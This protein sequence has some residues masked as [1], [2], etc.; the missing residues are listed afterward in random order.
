MERYQ[1]PKVQ[2]LVEDRKN[3]REKWQL[4]SIN[5]LIVRFLN[6]SCA[7]Y[8]FASFLYFFYIFLIV[9]LGGCMDMVVLKPVFLLAAP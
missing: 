3:N 4:K 7:I 8:V 9:H 1:E 5:V 6:Y 2:T